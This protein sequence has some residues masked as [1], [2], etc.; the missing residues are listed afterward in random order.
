LPQGPG[1]KTVLN[2]WGQKNSQTKGSHLEEC[3]IFSDKRRPGKK[4][5]SNLFIDWEIL[6]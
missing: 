6:I 2:E 4:R 1:Q 3:K 5:F